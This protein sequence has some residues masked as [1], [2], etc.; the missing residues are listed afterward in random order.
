MHIWMT[1]LLKLGWEEGKKRPEE[2]NRT[3]QGR[4]W[5]SKK[6]GNTRKKGDR[7]KKLHDALACLAST[8]SQYSKV[9]IQLRMLHFWHYCK[10]CYSMPWLVKLL[11]S[12]LFIAGAQNGITAHAYRGSLSSSPPRC[13]ARRNAQIIETPV[14]KIV[15]H[16]KSHPQRGKT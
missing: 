5:M 8:L 14:V 9:V 6:R 11:D 15:L 10:S 13:A 3:I 2:G 4:K 12:Y 16:Q 1:K 7:K